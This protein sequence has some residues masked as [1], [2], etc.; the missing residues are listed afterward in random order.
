MLSRFAG[1]DELR[2]VLLLPSLLR[3]MCGGREQASAGLI[4][5][6]FLKSVLDGFPSF[7]MTQADAALQETASM[8]ARMI[9]ADA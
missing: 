9:G 3:R 8:Q 5:K 2:S 6:A 1:R 4:I 7:H